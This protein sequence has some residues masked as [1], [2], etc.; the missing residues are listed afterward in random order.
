MV[1]CY[2]NIIKDSIMNQEVLEKEME[3]PRDYGL[4]TLTCK[5]CGHKWIPRILAVTVCPKCRSP[6][7][8]KPRTVP[9]KGKGK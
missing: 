5:R 7:W 3:M 4:P 6:Y 1:Y 8:K 9:K 2:P